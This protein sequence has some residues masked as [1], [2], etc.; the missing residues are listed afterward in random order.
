MRTCFR[1]SSCR[2]HLE[3]HL[4]TSG[5]I[6]GVHQERSFHQR[7]HGIHIHAVHQH[8]SHM[9]THASPRS[10][11]LCHRCWASRQVPRG[12][13]R[14]TLLMAAAQAAAAAGFWHRRTAAVRQEGDHAVRGPGSLAYGGCVAMLLTLSSSSRHASTQPWSPGHLCTQHQRSEAP[15]KHC[16]EQ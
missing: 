10:C 5:A 2:S 7:H 14:S 11:A 13:L 9:R 1:T 6:H 15:N 4:A 12:A 16:A 3:T 8:P